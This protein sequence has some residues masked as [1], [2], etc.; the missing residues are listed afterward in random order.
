VKLRGLVAA[1]ILCVRPLLGQQDVS[2]QLGAR[3]P[4]PVL[5]AIA[6]LADSA[7]AKGLP[8]DPILE[9][10]IEGSTK[11]VP[12]DRIVG[13]ARAVLGALETSAR[14]TRAGGVAAPGADVVE[15]GAFALNAG[16]QPA[17]VT[18]L[19]HGSEA[20]YAPALVLRVAGTLAALGVSAAQSVRVVERALDAHASPADLADLPRQ[21][22]LGMARGASP[23]DA[24]NGLGHGVPHGPPPGSPPPSA[25]HGPPPQLPPGPP[26]GPGGRGP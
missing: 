17:D 15:A 19:V 21:L 18:A 7:V 2:G 9:K 24:A 3:L 13:A 4:P 22:Q 26:H 5:A 8:S 14:A 25:G 10:A 20:S 12:G 23:G 11:G 16:L 1:S 6:S